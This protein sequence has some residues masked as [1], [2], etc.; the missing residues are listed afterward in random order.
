MLRPAL[1][2]SLVQA[3]LAGVLTLVICVMILLGREVPTQ[4][5]DLLLVAWAF[6]F[7]ATLTTNNH[8]R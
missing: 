4:A 7:G 6:Y 1:E 2:K 5:W 3:I 8:R